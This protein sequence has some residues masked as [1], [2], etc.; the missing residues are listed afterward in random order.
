MWR[1]RDRTIGRRRKRVEVLTRQGWRVWGLIAGFLLAVW[2]IAAWFGISQDRKERASDNL[3]EIVLQAR[4]IFVYD[5]S[6]LQPGQTRFFSYLA[7]P[8]ERS[9]LLVQR[10]SDGVIRTAL[11]SC[12]S[13]YS[14]RHE[15]KLIKGRLICGKCQSAMRIGDQKERLTPDKGC[16]AVPVTFSVAD[17][18]VSVR[19]EAITEGIKAFANLNHDAVQGQANSKATE[20]HP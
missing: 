13:C 8:S 15:H 20:D 9:R 3:P 1:S 18:K 11:A 2:G 14:Y 6:Q 17:N 16:V 12:T 4:E 10:D 19:P 7:G 5:L